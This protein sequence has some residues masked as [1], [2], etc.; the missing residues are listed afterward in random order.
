MDW[1]EEGL[2]FRCTGCGRCCI[3][4]GYVWVTVEEIRALAAH[5][6]LDLDSFGRRYLMRVGRRYSLRETPKEHRCVLLGE[7]ERCTVYDVRPRQCRTF[8]FWKDWLGSRREWEELTEECPGVGRGPLYTVDEIR[9]IAEG[10][11]ETG[12]SAGS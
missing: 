3:G 9:E 10:R 1:I 7:D 12:P 11:R 8:P 6:R 5:L 4:A 2:R